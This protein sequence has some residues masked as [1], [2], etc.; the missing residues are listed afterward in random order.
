[1]LFRSE[2][3]G[4]RELKREGKKRADVQVIETANKSKLNTG[5]STK[6]LDFFD[7]PEGATSY[8]TEIVR[9]YF[10]IVAGSGIPA[11]DPYIDV[12]QEVLA[13]YPNYN[14]GFWQDKVDQKYYP[15]DE[16]KKLMTDNGYPF[17]R[18]SRSFYI[19]YNDAE[20]KA[21]FVGVGKYEQ[22]I[23]LN[24]HLAIIDLGKKNALLDATRSRDLQ[25]YFRALDKEQYARDKALDRI[26]DR[27]QKT[28]K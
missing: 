11:T 19:F 1:M 20:K 10:Y 21:Y 25:S 28:L 15:T 14:L 17:L 27:I 22:K 5:T 13:L 7:V 9:G 26:I 2:T 18:T 8:E 12:V 6:E 24:A 3:L 16:F 4:S 23:V